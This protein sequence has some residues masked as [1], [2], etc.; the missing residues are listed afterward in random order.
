MTKA[1]AYLFYYHLALFSNFTFFL[2]DPDNGD[3]FEQRDRRVVIGSNASQTWFTTWLGISMD[4]T[5]GLQ[6]R[7]DAIPEV[8]LHKTRERTR[9]STVRDDTV[10]ETS[11]GMYYQNHTQS[12][13]PPNRSAVWGELVRPG[14]QALSPAP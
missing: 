10:H 6:V 14:V 7:H 12:P 9:L 11:V 2:D 5:L 4:H 8:G 13:T 1:N 3:Q